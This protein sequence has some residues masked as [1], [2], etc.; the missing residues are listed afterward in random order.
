MTLHFTEDDYNGVH[1]YDL[2]GGEKQL[3]ALD[4]VLKTDPEAGDT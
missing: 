4:M 1:P 3:A 2:S